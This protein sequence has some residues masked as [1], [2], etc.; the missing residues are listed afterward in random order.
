MSLKIQIGNSV[1]RFVL[2]TTNLESFHSKK[3][4]NHTA[5]NLYLQ[6]VSILTIAK[7]T[8]STRSD[9]TLQMNVKELRAITMC[10][11]FTPECRHENI[12]I[13]LDGNVYCRIQCV[14]I[15]FACKKRIYTLLNEV[16]VKVLNGRPR[17]KCAKFP[18]KNKE[19]RFS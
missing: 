6:K 7:F 2:E 8:T 4:L 18:L 10:S 11:A 19:F 1:Y 12:I 14:W 5:I 16:T 9:I 17:V 13:K 3:S 15:N